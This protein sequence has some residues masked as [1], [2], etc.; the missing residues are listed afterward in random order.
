[1]GYSGGME[2]TEFMLWKAIAIVALAFLAGLFGFIEPESK[3]GRDK[4]RE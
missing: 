3:E 1:M 4:R 2:F